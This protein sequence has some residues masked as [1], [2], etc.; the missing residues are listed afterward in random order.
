MLRQFKHTRFIKLNDSLSLTGC[1]W[2]VQAGKSIEPIDNENDNKHI[3]PNCV[4][5]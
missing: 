3:R 5:T 4:R 2:Y 1:Y